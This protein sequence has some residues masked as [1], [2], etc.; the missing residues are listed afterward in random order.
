[1]R[2]VLYIKNKSKEH[3]QRDEVQQETPSF[4]FSQWPIVL[5][6]SSSAGREDGDGGVRHKE[7]QQHQGRRGNGTAPRIV[8]LFAHSHGSYINVPEF[9]S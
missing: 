2:G 1:M 5:C 4:H 3:R 8:V 9:G 7:C 6:S